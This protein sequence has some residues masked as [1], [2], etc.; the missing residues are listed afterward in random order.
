MISHRLE[1]LV[2]LF[3]RRNYDAFSFSD[4]QKEAIIYLADGKHTEISFGGAAGGGKSWL[5][6][7]WLLL[8]CLAYPMTKWFIGRA[9]LKRIRQSTYITFLKVCRAYNFEDYK[10]NFQ[11]NYIQFNNGSRID[12]LDLQRMPRDPM[13]E[14]FGSIEYTG[15]WIE[16]AGEIDFGAFEVLKSRCGRH[17]N[18]EYGITRKILTTLNPK[19]NWCHERYWVPFKEKQMPE[20]RVF[21]QSL[22]TDNPFI[23]PAYIENLRSI[24]DK[25]KKQRLLYGNFDY[26]DDDNSLTTYDK[27][28][29]MFSNTFVDEGHPFISADIAI[30]SDSFVLVAWLGLRIKEIRV[31]KNASKPVATEVDG[32]VQTSIDYTPLVAQFNELSEKYKVPRSSIIYDADG[33]GHNMRKYLSGAIGINN[34]SPSISG[35]YNHLKSELYYRL[36][37][38]VNKSNIYFDC[39]INDDLKKRIISEFQAIKRSSDVGEK[40]KIMKKSEVKEIIGHSP[41]ITDAIAYRMMFLITRRK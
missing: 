33:I 10:T 27:I 22:V 20:D 13:F 4:K 23:D 5:G 21:I 18:V 34:G 29:D 30:T 41:D 12:L 9:E 3:K 15:G 39:Y 36:A 2:E 24:T 6:C 7:E 26:D 40:L 35:E 16:E 19:K 17:M 8:M 25:V 14:R 37:E 31:I 1:I 28:I 38:E 11:D 32:V